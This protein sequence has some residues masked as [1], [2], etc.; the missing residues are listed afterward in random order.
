MSRRG[1]KNPCK[2]LSKWIGRNTEFDCGYTV[3]SVQCGLWRDILAAIVPDAVNVAG[4]QPACRSFVRGQ[5]STTHDMAGASASQ[6]TTSSFDLRQFSREHNYGVVFEGYLKVLRMASTGMKQIQMTVQ[7]WVDGEEVINN[8]G[9]HA[10]RLPE[11]RVYSPAT[12]PH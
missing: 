5:F 3:W 10:A 12:P 7:S 6:G 2:C 1:T 8:D 4:A 9:I 11:S